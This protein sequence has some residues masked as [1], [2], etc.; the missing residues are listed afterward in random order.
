M[1][2]YRK[3]DMGTE[4]QE[5]DGRLKKLERLEAQV[6]VFQGLAGM[7]LVTVLGLV[8][9]DCHA[10]DAET[11]EQAGIKQSI[12][13][14]VRQPHGVNQDTLDSMQ[15]TDKEHGERLWTI[16]KRLYIRKKK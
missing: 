8:A 3:V 13:H 2:P 11:I 9:K 10:R 14:H 4:L 12:E 15:N 7:L 16:E 1:R 6:R 5:H